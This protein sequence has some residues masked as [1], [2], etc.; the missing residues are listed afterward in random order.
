MSYKVKDL[1][2]DTNSKFN[3]KVF[4]EDKG[5]DK[6]IL[7]PLVH[8]LSLAVVGHYKLFPEK[9]IQVCGV[10]EYSYLEELL[11]EER[12]KRISDIF[13]KFGDSIPA[14]IF[15]AG[16]EPFPEIIELAKEKSVVILGT[17]YETVLFVNDLSI[18]LEEKLTKSSS[19]QGV[20]VNVYGVGIVI[21]GDSG[22]GKSEAAIELLKRGHMF[23]ADDIVKT[24]V[25][26]SGVLMGTSEGIIKDFIEVRGLGIVDVAAIFGVGIKMDRSRIDLLINLKLFSNFGEYDRLGSERKFLEILGVKIPQI[27]IPVGPGRNVSTLIEIAALN[28]KLQEKGYF[29]VEE[30]DKRVLRAID[31]KKHEK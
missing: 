13:E 19:L 10:T 25:S 12:Y 11:P 30:L 5:L 6:V 29:P 22:I 3:F 7:E 17:D 16:L 21:S 18:I 23:V 15:T 20:M 27:T 8:R 4:T 1:I 2:K 14:I 28:F 31:E 26:S 24:Y 9:R